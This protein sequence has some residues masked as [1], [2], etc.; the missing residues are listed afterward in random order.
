[1]ETEPTTKVFDDDDEF[2]DGPSSTSGTITKPNP[3]PKSGPAIPIPEL[4]SSS[5]ITELTDAQAQA[6]TAQAEA[7]EQARLFHEEQ[8]RRPEVMKRREVEKGIE[9]LK[10]V[11]WGNMGA[12]WVKKVGP[13]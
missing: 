3:K 12:V 11:V 2:N 10:K 6:L 1:M 4:P 8:E 7:E 9:E 5:G 13:S